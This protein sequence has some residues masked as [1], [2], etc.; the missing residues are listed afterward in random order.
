[1]YNIIGGGI[2]GSMVARQLSNMG[3]PFRIFDIKEAFAASKISENLFSPTWLKGIEYLD[4]SLKWLS[5]NYKIETKRFETNKS[6]QEVY[7][8]PVNTVLHPDAITKRVTQLTRN[9]LYCGTEFFSGV[10]IVCAGFFTKQLIKIDKLNALSGHGLLFEPN[11]SNSDL[12]EVMRHWRPFTHEKIL[13]WHDG[14]IWYGDSTAI[15]HNTY[16]KKKDQY[17]SETLKRAQE[18]GLKGNCQLQYG[19]RPFIDTSNKKYGL[20]KKIDNNTFV[21]T[22]GWKDGLVIYPYLISKLVKDL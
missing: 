14:R 12:K 19:A 2:C 3:L 11:Q 13:K 18:I 7:H 8:I 22:G 16:L 17:I 10:N 9:G 1:M 4:S 21:L 5:D 20:Y 6:V 15:L